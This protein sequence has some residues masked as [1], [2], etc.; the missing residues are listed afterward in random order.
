MIATR[1]AATATTAMS[2]QNHFTVTNR[3]FHLW[4]HAVMRISEWEKR[5]LKTQ[6]VHG[7]WHG[8]P[9]SSLK[10]DASSLYSYGCGTIGSMELSSFVTSACDISVFSSLFTVISSHEEIHE[11]SIFR[12]IA[13]DRHEMLQKKYHSR[14][15]SPSTWLFLYIYI[16]IWRNR[17]I[18]RV[19]VRSCFVQNSFYLLL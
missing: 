9:W 10:H 5:R 19:A 2:M 1:T 12:W 17:T 4:A 14:L 15:M 8:M 16:H 18:I 3:F 6:N 13:G 11:Y 7:Q